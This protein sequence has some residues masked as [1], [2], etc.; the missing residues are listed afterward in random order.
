MRIIWSL[1]KREVCRPVGGKNW[2]FAALFR[3][4]HNPKAE[5]NLIKARLKRAE[6]KHALHW[7]LSSRFSRGRL[8]MPTRG[9]IVGF[10]APM[11]ARKPGM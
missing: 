11:A 2:I 7:Q 6:E 9:G 10:Q 1:T 5:L 8:R 3:E 4:A